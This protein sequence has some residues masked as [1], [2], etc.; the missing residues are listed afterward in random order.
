MNERASERDGRLNDPMPS[1]TWR[2][3]ESCVRRSREGSQVEHCLCVATPSGRRRR[4]CHHSFASSARQHLT[5]PRD[6]RALEP[7][8]G[9]IMAHLNSVLAEPTGDDDAHQV[10]IGRRTLRSCD[11]IPSVAFAPIRSYSSRVR[12][13][14]Q[15]ATF[16]SVSLSIICC[17]GY[18]EPAGQRLSS[19]ATRICRLI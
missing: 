12:L 5:D 1:F 6:L 10:S 9:D 3:G 4:R 8:S 15:V 14:E 2:H 11:S 16:S 13:A 18:S 19:G 7:R 17:S